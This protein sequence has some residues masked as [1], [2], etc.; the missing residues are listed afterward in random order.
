MLAMTTIAPVRAHR[1]RVAEIF[2]N[3]YSVTAD[4]TIRRERREVA[5]WAVCDDR[6]TCGHCDGPFAV[7]ADAQDAASR[8]EGSTAYTSPA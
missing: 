1:T 7:F 8:H 2:V 5:W 6:E 4:G 3:D